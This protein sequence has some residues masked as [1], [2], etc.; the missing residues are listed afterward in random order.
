[1]KKKWYYI[2]TLIFSLAVALC[3][4]SSSDKEIYLGTDMIK[5]HSQ[6][7]E[8]FG[9]N[10]NLI[11][12][13]KNPDIEFVGFTGEHTQGLT[14][15]FEDDTYDTVENIE[16]AGYYIKLLGFV[17]QTADEDVRIDGVT[18]KIDGE[19]EYFEFGTPIQHSL[20]E[21]DEESAVFSSGYPLYISTCSYRDTKYEFRYRA[22]KKVTIE[23]FGF[24]DFLT[25]RDSVVLLDGERVGLG[26]CFPLEMEKDSELS[27][28]CYLDF[29]GAASYTDYDGVYCDAQLTYSV[30]GSPEKKMVSTNLVSQSVSNE[31]DAGEAIALILEKN[32][33]KSGKK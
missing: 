32:R 21:Y 15:K 16:R 6:G 1:M 22:D 27:I 14:V 33:S 28:L 8:E 18:L 4:C 23:G 2:A 7:V 17:C 30:S 31:D 26:S 3:G 11:S 10:V 12:P 29:D 24:N 13:D 20:M 9:F 5:Y 25:V 19:E